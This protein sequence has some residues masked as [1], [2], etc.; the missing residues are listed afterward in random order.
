MI[1][2]SVA[3]AALVFMAAINPCSA[4]QIG[5]LA[6][7]P[8]ADGTNVVPPQGATSNRL[9][10]INGNTGRVIYDDGG[11]DLFCITRRNM[12]GRNEYGERIY[13]RTMRCR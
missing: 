11:D 12:A 10:I 7:R 1:K 6:N 9:M 5:G 4:D 2:V 8:Q 3:T 13:R